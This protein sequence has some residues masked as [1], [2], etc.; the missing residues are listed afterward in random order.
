[1][2]FYVIITRSFVIHIYTFK[3]IQFKRNALDRIIFM[4]KLEVW[5]KHSQIPWKI[6]EILEIW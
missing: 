6:L 1:M 5:D 3:D 2:V 4:L